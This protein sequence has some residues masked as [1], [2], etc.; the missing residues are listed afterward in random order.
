[1][2]LETGSPPSHPRGESWEDNNVVIDN[3]VVVRVR[4]AEPP[5]QWLWL[6]KWLPAIPQ[7]L[8][9]AA[10]STGAYLADRATGGDQ[11]SV[12]APGPLRI[13]VIIAAFAVLLMT[14]YPPGLFDLIMG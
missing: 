13:C 7:P 3:P 2:A 6:V 9:V 10:I 1:M 4:L 12:H 14:R 8:I 5:S 11:W